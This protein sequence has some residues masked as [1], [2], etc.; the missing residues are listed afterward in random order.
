MKKPVHYSTLPISVTSMA[1][2]WSLGHCKGGL[3][4]VVSDNSPQH[5]VSLDGIGQLLEFDPTRSDN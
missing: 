4:T 1:Y 2:S 3:G 5:D